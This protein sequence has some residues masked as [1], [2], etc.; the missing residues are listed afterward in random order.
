MTASETN[1]KGRTVRIHLA[2]SILQVFYKNLLGF[3]QIYWQESLRDP[4]ISDSKFTDDS[5][6]VSTIFFTGCHLGLKRNGLIGVT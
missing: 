5:W 1:S 2:S 4:R 6:M 3:S